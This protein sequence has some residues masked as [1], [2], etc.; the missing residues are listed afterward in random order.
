MAL[1]TSVIDMIPNNLQDNPNLLDDV[2]KSRFKT[3]VY[4]KYKCCALFVLGFLALVQLSYI[5][6]NE[7]VKNEQLLNT[8]VRLLENTR[9]YNVTVT[10][11]LP[12][13]I[14]IET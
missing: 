8:M 9:L 13:I 11:E 7:V 10:Q 2:G 1:P 4:F 5:I 14:R 6:I 3:C 12:E